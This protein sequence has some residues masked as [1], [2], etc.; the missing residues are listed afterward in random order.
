[1][2]DQYCSMNTAKKG[3]IPIQLHLKN[4]FL[5]VY[6]YSGVQKI[7]IMK[8]KLQYIILCC[9]PTLCPSVLYIVLFFP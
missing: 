9:R 8:E 2:L 5:K 1:M 7:S 4:V 6:I 3:Y